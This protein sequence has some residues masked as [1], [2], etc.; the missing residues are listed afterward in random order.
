VRPGEHKT[1]P[2]WKPWKNRGAAAGAETKPAR[3]KPAALVKYDPC[4]NEAQSLDSCWPAWAPALR[5][6]GLTSATRGFPAPRTAN[7]TSP[8]LRRAR[9]TA[10]PTS[11]ESGRRIE[12]RVRSADALPPSC[13]RCGVAGPPHADAEECIEVLRDFLADATDREV[14]PRRGI[15]TLTKKPRRLIDRSTWPGR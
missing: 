5:R 6:S 9:R 14:K 15:A 13:P 8:R 12:R 1:P 7:R 10:S 4:T 2:T 11:R 3:V